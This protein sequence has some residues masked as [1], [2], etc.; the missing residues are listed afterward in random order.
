MIK[1]DEDKIKIPIEILCQMSMKKIMLAK[2]NK[3]FNENK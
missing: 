3:N 1:S 2:V